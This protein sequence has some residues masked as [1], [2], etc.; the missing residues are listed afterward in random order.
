[1]FYTRLSNE[2]LQKYPYP[3]LIAEW[4][5]S[6]Y[7]FCT[8]G[9]R[10]GLGNYCEEND[11]KVWAKLTGE[12]EILADEAAE[13]AALFGV[14]FKYLFSPE[15][16][17]LDGKSYAYWRWLESNKARERESQQI[18]ERDFIMRSLREKPYLFQVF[19]MFIPMSEKEIENVMKHGF[20]NYN[21]VGGVAV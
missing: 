4:R 15:L 19:K 11:P 6:G 10:M 16:K 1:M 12:K 21:M 7:S 8:L 5:E 17:V 14:D 13:L 20:Q 18:R 9:S 2:K 3:N